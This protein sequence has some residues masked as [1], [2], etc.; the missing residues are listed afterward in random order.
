M[1]IYL[2]LSNIN[3]L[4]MGVLDMGVLLQNKPTAALR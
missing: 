3:N 1:A 4:D 2:K